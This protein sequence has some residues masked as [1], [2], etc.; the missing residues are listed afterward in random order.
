MSFD[1]KQIET[2]IETAEGHSPWVK[3]PLHWKSEAAYWAWLRGNLRRMW[4]RWPPRIELKKEKRVSVKVYELKGTRRIL[5]R[6]KTGKRK[7]KPVTR[8]E[9]ECEQCKKT[10]A[11][12]KVEADHIEPAGSCNNAVEAVTFLYRLLCDKENLRMVCKGCHGIIT[13]AEKMNITFEEAEVEKRVIQLTKTSV[14]S[15]DKQKKQLLKYGCSEG[16]VK[17]A[18]SRKKTYRMLIKRG[19]I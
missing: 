5:K 14:N 8:Y 16:D 19:K 4:L 6:Y 17:N 15:V 9:V 18:A 11:Q 7:G 13:Y 12:N 1:R 3:Y 2:F 10:F